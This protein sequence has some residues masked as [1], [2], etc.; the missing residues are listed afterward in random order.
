M[1][2]PT[3]DGNDL[4]LCILFCFDGDNGDDGDN[5]NDGDE[6]GGMESV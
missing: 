6:E 4:K 5:G 3:V 2:V 1:A